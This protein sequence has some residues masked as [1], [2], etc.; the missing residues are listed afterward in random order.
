MNEQRNEQMKVIVTCT[1]SRWKAETITRNSNFQSRLLAYSTK[2]SS[3]LLESKQLS[4]LPFS[5][6]AFIQ[7]GA[8]IGLVIVLFS[9]KHVL[10]Y[11]SIWKGYYDKPC[12]CVKLGKIPEILRRNIRG[13]S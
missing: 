11:S 12:H 8:A 2:S 13:R 10:Y 9:T 1:R 4:T 5:M 7:Q 3:E 6:M